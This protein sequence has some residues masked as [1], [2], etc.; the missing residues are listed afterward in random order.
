MKSRII[1]IFI[2]LFCLVFVTSCKQKKEEE[3]RNEING[4]LN[5][6]VLPTSA[7]SKIELIKEINGLEVIWQSN[8]E[9]VINNDGTVFASLNDVE[10]NLVATISKEGITLS[11]TFTVVVLALDPIQVIENTFDKLNI[12]TEISANIELPEVVDNLKITWST[13]NKNVLTNR[14]VVKQG[15]EDIEVTLKASISYNGKNKS[16]EFKVVVLA[17]PIYKEIEELVNDLNIPLETYDNINLPTEYNGVSI[18]WKSSRSSVLSPEGIISRTY[19]DISVL[20]TATLSYNNVKIEKY[21]DVVVKG[22]TNR[23]KLQVI[24]DGLHF[25]SKLDY[26]LILSTSLGF[27]TIAIWESSNTDVLTNEGIYTYDANVT[28]ITLKV[29][30]KLGSDE[31]Q[32]EFEFTTYPKAENVKEH[33]VIERANDFDANNFD[34]V[35]LVDG[36]L[37]LKAGA[38]LGTYH[39]NIIST[40]EFNVVV[41]SWAAISS[42]TS[43]VE[44]QVSVRVDGVW[45]DYISYKE[46]GLGLNNRCNNQTNSISKLVEDEIF[47][48]NNKK[49]DAIKYVVTLRSTGEDTPKVSLVSFALEIPGYTYPVNISSYP[50]S[51]IH[52]VPL[53]YQGEVPTIGNSICSATSSTM[54]LK[55]KGESFKE[56]D[57]E[58]EHRY[59]ASI[60]FDHGNQIYGNWVYN[61]VAMS[62]YGYDSYVARFY[63]INELVH[64]LATV[65]P[66]ALSVKGQMTSD[67]KN[68]YTAGHLIVAIGYEI[69]PNGEITIVCNDPNVK[70]SMCR[71]SLTVMNNTWRNVAYVIE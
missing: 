54:L 58:Y 55:Y 42:T 57:S 45:S 22:W 15:S 65:G 32:K 40:K 52:E 5:S 66:C 8:N 35:E 70:G 3:I 62:A 4:Y 36:K 56:F 30:I 27:D 19:E 11:K 25:D 37:V 21:Y 64:H 23:E 9:Q 68:Y 14:G 20:L 61:T 34:N 10:V 13:S 43:T 29:T 1:A 67:I 60:V 38:K 31:M 53:L 28:N 71:Y 46:W 12:P 33:M 69:H 6:I 39:S 48:Q 17:N 41:G 44:L 2:L 24:Y 7:E 51:L 59:I 50:T 26:D 47:I 16:R 63:S 18:T 49:A